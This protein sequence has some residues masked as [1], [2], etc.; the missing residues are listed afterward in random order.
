MKRESIT[1]IFHNP[2]CSKSRNAVK[3]LDSRG[4]DFDIVKYL[5]SPPTEIMR[6]E[7]DEMLVPDD[8]AFE[9][10]PQTTSEMI[11]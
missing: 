5:E 10:L 1:T 2:R 4:I 3:L 9:F 6:F 11:P 7:D 8:D